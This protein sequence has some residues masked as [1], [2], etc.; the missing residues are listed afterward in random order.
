MGSTASPLATIGILSIGDMGIGIARLLL[1]ND[2]AVITN[3]SDR[4]SVIF[5]R[6]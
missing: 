6:Q 5:D 1:A 4:R 3:A 2:F